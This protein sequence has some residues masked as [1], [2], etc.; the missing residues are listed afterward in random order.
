VHDG[1]LALPVP[2][3]LK[4]GLGIAARGELEHL[5]AGLEDRVDGRLALRQLLLTPGEGR[6]TLGQLGFDGGEATAGRGQTRAQSDG[7]QQAGGQRHP[8]RRRLPRRDRRP[9]SAG[10]HSTHV[11]ADSLQQAL[12]KRRREVGGRLGSGQRQERRHLAVFVHLAPGLG[13]SR[14][15]RLE[16]ARLVGRQRAERV[17][18][19]QI[20]RGVGRRAGHRS[21]SK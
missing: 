15:E 20:Q 1:E 14:Q 2:E 7:E 16:P 6:L 19:G 11:L 9:G 13:R 17:G 4:A 21:R 10:Q 18:G 5:D 12:A 8:D 3:Q